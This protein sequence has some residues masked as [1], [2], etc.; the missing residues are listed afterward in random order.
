MKK[1]NR[2]IKKERKEEWKRE[3]EFYGGFGE[4]AGCGFKPWKSFVLEFCRLRLIR[5]LSPEFY[6]LAMVEWCGDEGLFGYKS[7]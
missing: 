1:E 3:E 2:K 6:K 4:F 5:D 7:R